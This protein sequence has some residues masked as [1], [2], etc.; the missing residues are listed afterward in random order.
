MLIAAIDVGMVNLGFILAIVSDETYEIEQIC[1]AQRID[2]TVFCHE[3]V[4]R[5]ECKLHHSNDACDRVQHFIQEYQPYL[6]EADVV[7]IERQPITGLIHI[8]QLL[9]QA[10]RDKAIL[11]SPTKMHTVLGMTRCDYDKR[12]EESIALAAPYLQDLEAWTEYA[13][14]RHDI[15]DAMCL[16]LF[17]TQLKQ[18]EHEKLVQKQE[19]NAAVEKV[20]GTSVDTFFEQFRCPQQS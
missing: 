15:S 13:D 2:L 4:S 18:D 17:W 20:L 10:F 16:I 1:L 8:E 3:R 7:L 5:K 19:R 14:R 12:K 11:C 6:Q 9:F